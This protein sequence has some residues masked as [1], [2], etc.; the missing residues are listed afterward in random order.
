MALQDYY[1]A[2]VGIFKIN[3]GSQL[4]DISPYILSLRGLPGQFVVNDVTTW[5]SVG[6]RPGPAIFVVHFIIEMLF[7]KV[8]DVGTWTVLN[9]MFSG[10]ALR[11]FEYY[12]IGTDGGNP[13]MYGNCIL[14]V[15]ENDATVR[16]EIRMH[17]E[18][19]ADNGISIG[20]A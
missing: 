9:G 11:A 8:S 2:K 19:H 6:E 16:N 3:D 17:A 13:K 10:K 7:N 20:T 4:R 18:F 5:G 15:F 1:D 14:P 12:P